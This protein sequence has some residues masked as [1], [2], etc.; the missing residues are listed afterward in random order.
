MVTII[1]GSSSKEELNKQLKKALKT[2]GVDTKKYCG[3]LTLK[4]DPIEI[5][6]RMRD[7]WK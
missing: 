1:K 6:K 5:Q 2:K 7:E 3:V 4:E